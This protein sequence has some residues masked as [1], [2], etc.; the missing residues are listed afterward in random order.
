MLFKMTKSKEAVKKFKILN[1]TV[2]LFYESMVFL[3]KE[4]IFLKFNLFLLMYNVLI[5]DIKW[6]SYTYIHIYIYILFHIIFY[7]VLS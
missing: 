3:L 7:Y 4:L 6:L 5:T 1:L 2:V